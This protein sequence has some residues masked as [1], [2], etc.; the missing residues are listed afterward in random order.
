MFGE[1]PV[2]ASYYKC[3]GKFE[4]IVR[5]PSAPPG[6]RLCLSLTGRTESQLVRDILEGRYDHVLNRD[7]REGVK[8]A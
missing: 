6:D 2:G 3:D 8:G 5:G 4:F 1:K 7:K